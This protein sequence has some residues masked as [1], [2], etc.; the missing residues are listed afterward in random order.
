M[1][2]F[3]PFDFLSCPVCSREVFEEL[4]PHGGVRCQTCG[5][6]FQCIPCGSDHGIVVNC[7]IANLER[8][9]SDALKAKGLIVTPRWPPSADEPLAYFY[10]V[11]K[12]CDMDMN[13]PGNG[14]AW[15]ITSA[16]SSTTAML[17]DSKGNPIWQYM[18]PG[19]LPQF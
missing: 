6:T 4:L 13:N 11:L 1:V 3:K 7:R 2:D 16:S 14:V 9:Y 18:V 12:P 17:R 5:A 15:I 19:I 10:T 8:E